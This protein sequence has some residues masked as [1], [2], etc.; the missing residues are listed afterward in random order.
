M[1]T[2]FLKL[3]LLTTL[4]IIPI[5]A[6]TISCSKQKVQEENKEDEIIPNLEQQLEDAA[7]KFTIKDKG[8][9]RSKVYAESVKDEVELKKYVDFEGQE[10][11]FEYTFKES[12]AIEK[13][14]LK[15]TY[16]I[17]IK[18]K[19]NTK[20]KEFILDGFRD[21]DWIDY[22]LENP[23]DFFKI[24]LDKEHLNTNAFFAQE[25]NFYT[26]KMFKTWKLTD[27]PER[28]E[29]TKTDQYFIFKDQKYYIWKINFKN[30]ENLKPI[31]AEFADSNHL[32]GEIEAVFTEKGAKRNP[33]LFAVK[34]E[35]VKEN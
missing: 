29:A 33:F 11:N 12:T 19:N 7:K 28:Y 16:T 8:V 9:D 30:T 31:I 27:K 21:V 13:T 25:Y 22:N 23:D 4:S 24:A 6:L 10:N 18:D 2:K 15:V 17:K 3:G 35:T 5:S 14:K 34:E 26:E 20:D 32:S 1:T